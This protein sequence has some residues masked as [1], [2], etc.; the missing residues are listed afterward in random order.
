MRTWFASTNAPMFP[1]TLW[2]RCAVTFV[3]FSN[4]YHRYCA[5]IQ[6]KVATVPQDD[7]FRFIR[8]NVIKVLYKFQYIVYN[9]TLLVMLMGNRVNR[10]QQDWELAMPGL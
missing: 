9:K 2:P 10:Q 5:N 7:H 4:N 1:T 6:M 8:Q 3:H